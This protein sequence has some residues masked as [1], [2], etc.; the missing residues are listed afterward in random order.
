MSSTTANFQY[1]APTDFRI[2]QLPEGLPPEQQAAFSQIYSAIQQIIFSLVNNCGVGPRNVNQWVELNGNTTTVLQGN[3]S[4]FYIQA[5]ELI[6]FGAAV[7]LFN[8]G[9]TLL[10]RNANA[11][12]GTKPCR[13]FCTT[14]GGI[15]AGAVGEVQVALGTIPIAGLIPGSSYW[16]STTNGL[17]VNG[18]PAAAGNLEQYVGF[19]LS[20][21]ILAFNVGAGIQH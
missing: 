12:D 5:T 15:A 10:A 19:A 14:S 20:T 13:A 8:S 4:R 21:T 2:A 11:T 9:G 16:L 18:A 6:P 17:I 3:L 1:N 7:N